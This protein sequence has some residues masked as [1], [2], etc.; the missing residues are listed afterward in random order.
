MYRNPTAKYQGYKSIHSKSPTTAVVA[1]DGDEE[2]E[3]SHQYNI[4]KIIISRVVDKVIE[5]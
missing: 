2:E 1:I 3:Y 5:G 4:P